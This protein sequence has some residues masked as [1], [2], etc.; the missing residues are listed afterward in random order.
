MPL[1]LNGATSGSTTIQAT[2]AVTQTITLPNA[3]GTVI[4]T[5]NIPTGSVLQVV[6]ATSSTNFTTTSTTL[7]DTGF[8]ASITPSSSSNKILA[9]VNFNMYVFQNGAGQAYVYCRGSLARGST[10]LQEARLAYNS[11]TSSDIGQQAT[12]VYLDSPAT[13]S[14]TTYKLFV[15]SLNAAFSTQFNWTSSSTFTLMEIKG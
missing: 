3:T 14:S 10:Q 7:Q 2:D 12:I 6:S 15:S 13:T 8:S 4:T 1:I 5:G 11:G 9:I